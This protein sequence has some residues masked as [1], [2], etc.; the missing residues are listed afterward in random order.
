MSKDDKDYYSK[1][2]K[3]PEKEKVHI[4]GVMEKKDEEKKEVAGRS[5]KK[6]WER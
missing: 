3:V 4:G 5:K 1:K 2:N 6:N